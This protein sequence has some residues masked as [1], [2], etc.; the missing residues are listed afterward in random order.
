MVFSSQAIFETDPPAPI[1]RALIRSLRGKYAGLGL[2][3][4]L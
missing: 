4:G 2:M 3:K 1:T